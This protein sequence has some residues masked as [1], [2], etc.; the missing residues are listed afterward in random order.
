MSY[1]ETS[2]KLPPVYGGEPHAG[3]GE[4]IARPALAPHP[5]AHA[6]NTLVELQEVV[7]DYQLGHTTVQ[8]LRGVSLTIL[9]GEF[10]AVWGPS[11]SGKSTLLNLVGLVDTPT[12]GRITLAGEPVAGLRDREVTR[13]RNHHIGFVFQTFNLVPV[14]SALEN[15]MLP[16]Q[17]RGVAT[18]AARGKA[19]DLLHEVGLAGQARSRPDQLSGGQRQRVAIA[20]ALVTDPR[21]VVADEP[22]ANLDSDNS[23]RVLELMRALNRKSGATFLFSTHD[24]RVLAHIDRR[25]RIEDGLLIGSDAEPHTGVH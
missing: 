4:P 9:E 22:T 15:V 6:A 25:V 7:K 18:R 1:V 11:G 13:L 19:L 16:L 10:V 8:A 12:S 24:T 14:L 3:P 23:D 17:I 5:G 21:L 20:R 2:P